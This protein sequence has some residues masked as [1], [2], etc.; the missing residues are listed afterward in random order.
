MLLAHDNEHGC[1]PKMNTPNSISDQVRYQ[2]GY[3]Y[4]RVNRAVSHGHFIGRGKKICYNP[5]EIIKDKAIG[6][7]RRGTQRAKN[8]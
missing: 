2:P 5:M 7:S 3:W 1:Y 8:A 4:N 6:F